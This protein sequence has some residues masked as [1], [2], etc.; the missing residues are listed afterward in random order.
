MTLQGLEKQEAGT[1]SSMELHF[2]GIWYLTS[3]NENKKMCC[4][5]LSK[6]FEEKTGSLNDLGMI[7]KRS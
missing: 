3:S 5:S 7:H 1:P 6:V 4:A 2:Y